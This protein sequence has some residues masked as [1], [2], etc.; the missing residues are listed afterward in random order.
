MTG[1]IDHVSVCICTY[2]RARLLDHLLEALR[3]QRVSDDFEYSVVVV[4]NDHEE[5]ARPVVLA[6]IEDSPIEI[7]YFV[8]PRQNI[9]LA[10][11][12]A[13]TQATGNLVA[14]IDDDEVPCT[15][16]LYLMYRALIA[17]GVDGVLGPVKPRAD[18]EPPGW[19][20]KSKLLERKSFPTGTE[21]KKGY[22][23][24][25]NVLLWK[26]VFGESTEPFDPRLG[27]TGGEDTDFFGRMLDA[28]KVFVW[29]EEAVAFET[30]P[31]ERLERKYLLKRALLRGQVSSRGAPLISSS[32]M[33]SLVAVALYGALLPFFLLVRHDLFMKYLVKSCDH[34]GK[35]LALCG[36]NLVRDRGRLDEAP[37]VDAPRATGTSEGN[38]QLSAVPRKRTE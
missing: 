18:I 12:K 24:S 23:R 1:N 30:L 21:L 29:C 15:E 10:R 25:G 7:R 38:R 2:R 3:S 5:S 11:N 19:L 31:P 35:L 9:S 17:H 13:V 14:L 33:K 37:G 20:V 27:R 16:W 22:A 32:T 36:V 34:M 28:G 26:H 6:H 4:D 8:E